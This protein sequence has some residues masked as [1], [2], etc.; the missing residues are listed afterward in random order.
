MKKILLIFPE[1]FNSKLEIRYPPFG[2]VD[3]ASYIN[4]NGGLVTLY[5]RNLDGNTIEKL[6][7]QIQQD[8][9]EY[10]GISS[11]FIQKDDAVIILNRLKNSFKGKILVGGDYFTTYKEQYKK[12]VNYVICGEG[13]VFLQN[14]LSCEIEDGIHYTQIIKHLDDI[15]IPS[16]ELLNSVAWDKRVFALKTSRGCPFHCIFCSSTNNSCKKVRFYSAEYIVDYLEFIN[17]TYGISKFRFMDDVFTLNKQRVLEFCNLL[18][19]RNLNIEIV[20]CFSH[21][22]VNDKKMFASM[23]ECGFKSIQVGIESGNNDIL[24]LIGKNI[25]TD[26]ILDTVNTIRSSG[27]LAE[28]LFMMGNI[29]ETRETILSSIEFMKSLPTYKDWFSFACPLPN[30]EFYELAKVNGKI[31]E[32]NFNYYTNSQVVYVPNGMTKE[33]LEELMQY[34]KMNIREKIINNIRNKN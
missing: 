18:K 14:L 5:D 10:V 34:A 24:K 33:E 20:E 19:K 3:M 30:S 32:K 27:L 13:E 21:I 8:N 12:Q 9:F 28:G 2:L 17:N 29:G 31:I 23:A 26:Q 15:P 16:E 4:S 1:I 25:T 6:F 22:S 7:D 11:M